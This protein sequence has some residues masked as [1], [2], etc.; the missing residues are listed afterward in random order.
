MYIGLV[1][2]PLLLTHY[3]QFCPLSGIH[4]SWGGGGG[5]GGGWGLGYP[6]KAQISPPP[7]IF[8]IIINL[9]GAKYKV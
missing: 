5:G 7:K 4:T 3:Y 9:F 2:C 6:P 8:I 1:L